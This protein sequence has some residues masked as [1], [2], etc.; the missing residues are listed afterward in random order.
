MMRFCYVR[1]CTLS[2]VQEYW[3]NKADGDT[4]D[5]KM[6]MVKGCLVGLFSSE[7][8]LVYIPPGLVVWW[9]AIS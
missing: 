8:K 7:E 5:E 9:Y 2:E 1:Y 3:Q 4:V 6:V